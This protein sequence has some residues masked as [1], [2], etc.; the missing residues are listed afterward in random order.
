MELDYLFV[1]AHPD[2]I[3]IFVGG[4]L[5]TFKDLG[6]KV[7]ILDLTKGEAGSLGTVKTRQA[8][9]E[10]AN[11]IMQLDFRKTLDLQDCG[12]EVDDNSVEAVVQVIRQTRP[13]AIVTFPSPTRHPD[14]EAVHHIVRKSFFLAG[15]KN[16][17]PTLKAAYRPHALFFFVEFFSPKKVDFTV[18]ITSVYERKEA[19]VQCYETQVLSKKTLTSTEK[20]G[21][22]YQE[23]K[24]YPTFIHSSAFWDDFEGKAKWFGSLSGVRYAEAFTVW[25]PPHLQNPVEHFLKKQR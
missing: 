19:L 11:K 2:D 8:E 25:N 4:S 17:R 9:I 1:G 18:D 16:Y 7:G 15:V 6:L 22:Q 23:K 3:E 21:Q 5:L 10:S 24:S 12:L 14:H 20:D 13:K